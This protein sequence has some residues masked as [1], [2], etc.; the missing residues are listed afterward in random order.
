[1]DE[2]IDV[3]KPVESLSDRCLA[4]IEEKRERVLSGKINSI[5]LPFKRF[6]NTYP[7][8]ERGRYIL[9]TANQKIG[10]SK[11]S[12]FMFMYEPFFYYLEHPDELRLKVIYF[13]LEINKEDKMNEFYCHL[14]WKLNRL[15]ISTGN[16]KKYANKSC[17]LL[18]MDEAHHAF[19]ELK[20]Q[21]LMSLKVNRAIALSATI[22][23][24][25][26]Y[27]FNDI[28]K[29]MAVYTITMEEAIEMEIL[30]KPKVYLIPLKLDNSKKS[31][32]IEF[33]RGRNINEIHCDYLQRNSYIYAKNKYPTLNLIIHCTQQEKYDYLEANYERARI[34]KRSGWLRHGGIRKKFLSDC[35][36]DK[37]M[38]ITQNLELIEKRFICFCGSIEQA[39]ILGKNNCIHSKK[40]VKSIIHKFQSKEI[41]SLYAIKMLTEG[42]N[43][44]GIEAGII[45]QLDGTERPFVQRNGRMLRA[46]FPE[47]YILYFVGTKDEDY[48]ENVTNNIPKEYLIKL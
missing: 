8:A 13:T 12:D 5:P 40:E 34:Y 41:N 6:R 11:L 44:E 9:I 23:D 10:K 47:I 2:H 19:G 17:D 38:E 42:Q 22:A 35:K 16:L 24:E 29:S 48:L 32:T 25:H 4:K 15:I 37:L 20:S 43:L 30:P 33:K 1:M 28:F 21:L 36:T 14:L 3:E 45:G 27:L 46:E 18:I 26:K 39:E 31:E 7:G